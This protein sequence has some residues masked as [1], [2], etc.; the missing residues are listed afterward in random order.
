[1]TTIET[2]SG[3][4]FLIKDRLLPLQINY[5]ELINSDAVLGYFYTLSDE[6]LV[7]FVE[8][9]PY[10]YEYEDYA[11]MPLYLLYTLKQ[12]KS[13]KRRFS[14]GTESVKLSF[15]SLCLLHGIKDSLEDYLI[16][17]RKIN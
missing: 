2:K 8:L 17:H 14:N 1:M 15:K 4:L 3:T 9:H 12:Y 10:S 11:L 13:N 7:E 5:P 16:I 6:D